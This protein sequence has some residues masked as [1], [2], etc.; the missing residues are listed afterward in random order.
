VS[1]VVFDCTY[2]EEEAV[3]VGIGRGVFWEAS[4]L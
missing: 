1:G 4:C 3:L 2:I